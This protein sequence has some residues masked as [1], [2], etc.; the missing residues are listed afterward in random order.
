MPRIPEEVIDE[1]RQ[2]ADIAD[3]VGAYV[4]LKQRG[5]E[6]WGCCPFHKEKTP[7]FKV[8]STYQSYKCFGCGKSGSVFGFIQDIENM[9]FVD[10][11]RLLAQRTGVE[12]PEGGP[13]SSPE[14]RQTRR[15]DK[16]RGLDLLASVAQWYRS[17]LRAPHARK[18]RLYLGGRGL[19]KEA[20]DA[21]C[22]GYAPD[23]FD[24]TMGWALQQG[25]STQD[26]LATGMATQSEEHPE[27]PPYDRFRGRV[28]FAIHDEMGKVIGFSGRVLEADAKAA[29]YVNSP[30]T[31]FFHKSRVLYGFHL[32]RQSF[33]EAGCA[34]VC[35][36][37]LDVIACH[38]AGL[39]HT[40]C[41]QGTAFT[42]DHVRRL[43]RSTQRVL[44]A[45]DADSAGRKA[46]LRSIE[47]CHAAEI[48][49]GVIALAKG[50]DPDGVY[51]ERGAEGL[52][53]A[54]AK[55][56]EAIPYAFDCAR[57]EVDAGTPEGMNSVVR[58]VLS[59]V[60]PIPTPVTRVGH[61]RWLARALSL[62]EEPVL[63]TLDQM[64]SRQN[65]MSSRPPRGDQP[66]GGREAPYGSGPPVFVPPPPVLAP[67]QE[68][69]ALC[70]LMEMSLLS[71]TAGK[72][73]AQR[74]PA[75][76]IAGTPVGQALNLVLA[77]AEEGEWG[78]AVSELRRH[79]ELLANPDIGRILLNDQH[80]RLNPEACEG[81]ERTKVQERLEKAVADCV[82]QLRVREIDGRIAANQQAQAVAADTEVARQLQREH[83]ELV[84]E[85]QKLRQEIG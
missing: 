11:V 73:V 23:S 30:E 46:A 74:L 18:A 66:W 82:V 9:D 4:T 50:E 83:F 14:E 1:I 57:E 43:R 80:G 44:L 16:E 19:D 67:S 45:F 36:G 68:D 8:S 53:E 60:V 41:A 24:A 51:H 21:F 56:T 15:D 26:L 71:E 52:Q 78:D 2:R 6:S 58:D 27:R 61:A 42:E 77:H 59:L 76:L 72:V 62:P 69:V 55:V 37:Q 48:S 65:M 79:D 5:S 31:A 63:Q 33:K 17:Q 20:A 49:V 75:E 64:M 40:V 28:M 47:L 84:I 7:S 13:N 25:Y 22:I 35:E 39:T 29:K 38:R 10:A 3:V 70:M 85:K 34:I 32:A 12:I 54:V 81:K